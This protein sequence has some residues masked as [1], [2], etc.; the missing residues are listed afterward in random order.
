MS[1]EAVEK[2]II[3]SVTLMAGMFRQEVTDPMLQGYLLDYSA[4][5]KA[6]HL[7]HWEQGQLEEKSDAELRGRVSAAQELAGLQF[8]HLVSFYQTDDQNKE[9]ANERSEE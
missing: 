4:V 6:A 7:A 3:A 5:L 9:Q 1:S 8:E 2:E